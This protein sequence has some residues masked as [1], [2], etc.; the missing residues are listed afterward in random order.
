MHEKLAKVHAAGLKCTFTDI[1]NLQKKGCNLMKIW[2][3]FS[4][5][6]NYSNFPC[7]MLLIKNY[8]SV[9]LGIFFR[10]R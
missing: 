7:K 10:V 5:S 2:L 8:R 1:A 9:N 4:M 6:V 3:T